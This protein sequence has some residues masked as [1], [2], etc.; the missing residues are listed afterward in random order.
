MGDL[1]SKTIIVAGTGPGLG[2]ETA[3]ASY[4]QGANVVI[5]ARTAAKLDAIAQEVDATGERVAKVTADITDEGDC[6]AIIQAAVDRFGSVDG[7]VNVAVR[8][9]DQGGLQLAGD[10]SAWRET[11]EVNVFGTMRLI[12]F[13]LDELKKSKGAVVMVNAQTYHAPPPGQIQIAYASSKA[14]LTGAMRHLAAEIGPD[15]IRVNEVTPG[16]MLGPPVEHYIER[17][18]T[19]RG[20]DPGT[21]LAELTAQWPLRRMATDGDVAEAIAFLLSERAAGITGQTL[22]VNA[23]HVMH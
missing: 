6:H 13:A 16:W 7:I 8:S 17:T 14:A 20:V 15:G 19:E 1:D 9:G 22:M 12:Q 11:F 3:L 5:V 23:G 21:V 2:R 18:A 4:R 10:F